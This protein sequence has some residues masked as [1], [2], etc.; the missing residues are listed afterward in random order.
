MT[1]AMLTDF[2]PALLHEIENLIF[3]VLKDRNLRAGELIPLLG[4]QVVF[5]R[6]GIPAA[7]IRRGLNSMTAKGWLASSPHVRLTEMG[8]FQLRLRQLLRK[9]T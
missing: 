6:M 2:R 7:E 5:K 4:L 1:Q 3:Q 8:L 9:L